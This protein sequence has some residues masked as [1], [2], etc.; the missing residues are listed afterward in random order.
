MAVTLRS[1]CRMQ[2]K[3]LH[4][5]TTEVSCMHMRYR[6]CGLHNLKQFCQET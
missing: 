1:L 2:H 3:H 6:K 5:S 4:V